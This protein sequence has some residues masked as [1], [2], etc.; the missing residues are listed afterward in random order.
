MKKTPR[1]ELERLN[2]LNSNEGFYGTHN[3]FAKLIESRYYNKAIE[4]MNKLN[5]GFLWVDERGVHSKIYNMLLDG[6][7]IKEIKLKIL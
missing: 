2:K 5:Q 4:I 7:S 1:M 3:E 6:V